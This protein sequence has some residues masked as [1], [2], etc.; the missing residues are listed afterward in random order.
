[1]Y[2]PL[3]PEWVGQTLGKVRIDKYL[4][5][6]GM[7]EV[8]VGTHLTLDR[9]VAI[10]VLHSHTASNPTL[11]SRFEQEARAIA[12][13]RHPNIVH[14]LDFDTH[15]GHPYIVMEYIKGPALSHYLR[16]MQDHK[17]NIPLNQ[18]GHLLGSIA[19]GLDYAHAQGVIHRDIKPANILLH[20]LHGEVTVDSSLTNE[21]EPIL[22]DFGLAR[23]T[24]SVTQ[25]ESGVVSGTPV[26]MSPEQ[27]RGAKVDHRSDLYSL[28]VL[29]YEMLAGRVPFEGESTVTVILK[30][31]NEPPPPIE[32]I[33]PEL[34][35]II[36]KALAKDPD[37]RYQS[38]RALAMDFFEAVDMYA[39]ARTIHELSLPRPNNNSA[40][41]SY[42]RKSKRNMLWI[43]T[44]ILACICVSTAFASTLGLSTWAL[45]PDWKIAKLNPAEVLPAAALTQDVQTINSSVG[46]F[47]FQDGSAILDQVTI[48][49]IL[50]KSAPNTQYEAW[51]ISEDGGERRSLGILTLGSAG[52]F[53]LNYV[54]PQ[55]RNL[56]DGFNRMEITIE[57]TPDDSPNPSGNI[58]YSS[59]IPG[60]SLVHMRH[61]LV[62]HEGTPD[63][64][65]LAIGL[66]NTT[67]LI[68][69]YADQMVS[70]FE[71]NDPARARIKAEA[72]LNMIHGS[73]NTELYKDWD[74]NQKILDPSD[75]FGLLL[76][77]DQAGYVDGTIAYAKLAAESVDS[78]DDIRMHAEHTVIS[79][80]NMQGWFIQLRN[81]VM[82]IV[83]AEAGDDMEADVYAANALADQI[84]A[85]IDIDGNE[86]IDPI[87]GEGG[88]MTAYQ[89]AKYMADMPIL[90]GRD[91]IP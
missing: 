7:A 67:E 76:N 75:G 58:V 64:T 43:S 51:L 57:K 59:G 77:G 72:I 33:S 46:V 63:K 87:V 31:I 80:Q 8:Y 26:Y 50:T 22:T 62:A 66:V 11:Q 30:L 36:G 48:S 47:R 23:V 39:E 4:A 24:H 83:Q 21:I 56:L 68:E 74:G 71:E 19:T 69:E 28:G 12:A 3:M 27:A 78:T 38:A 79:A 49:S 9:P 88:A 81:I 53:A 42:G 61:L 40:S 29:L 70:D 90:L 65:A 89:H 6:G 45:S 32:N 35:S 25:T 5:S 55:S 2:N 73:Q 17:I 54:D 91:R 13:L 18:I 20:S 15:N 86:S 10:K 14:I 52:K 60:E 44:G 85:G 41:S 34:Q 16:T 1:M 37:H 84:L 82:R